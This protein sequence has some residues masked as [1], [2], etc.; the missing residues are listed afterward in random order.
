MPKNLAEIAEAGLTVLCGAA[1]FAPELVDWQDDHGQEHD[2]AE[3][4][5]PVEVEHHRDEDQ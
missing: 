1:D 2:G 4:H 3:C 5:S